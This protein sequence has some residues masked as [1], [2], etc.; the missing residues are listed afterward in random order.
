MTPAPPSPEIAR[1]RALHDQGWTDD[2][3]ARK[4]G[5]FPE[6][7]K[8]HVNEYELEKRIAPPRTVP[9]GT[10]PGAK[11]GSLLPAAGPVMPVGRPASQPLPREHGGAGA[12][13]GK[14]N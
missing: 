2:N 7:V 9:A 10:P 3:I 4:F 5:K 8:F 14:E 1:L 13:G 12:A 11:V 6:W